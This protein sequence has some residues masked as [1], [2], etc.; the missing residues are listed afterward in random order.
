M[1]ICFYVVLL[2]VD[3]AVLRTLI[4]IGGKGTKKNATLQI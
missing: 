2:L 1:L 3:Y 4:K